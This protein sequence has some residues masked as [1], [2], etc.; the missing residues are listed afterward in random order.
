MRGT[1][2]TSLPLEE[3]KRRSNITERAKA[4]GDSADYSE[5]IRVGLPGER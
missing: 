3:L 2:D 1:I 5:Q 4:A